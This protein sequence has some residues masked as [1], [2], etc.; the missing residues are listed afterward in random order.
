MHRG[1]EYI[2]PFREIVASTHLY[3][4]PSQFER[5]SQLV[6]V[7][8]HVRPGLGAAYYIG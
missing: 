3:L 4:P 6:L 8:N 7:R 2:H 5:H 1:E